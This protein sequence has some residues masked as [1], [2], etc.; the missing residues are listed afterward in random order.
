LEFGCGE[1]KSVSFSCD[2]RTLATVSGSTI[3]LWDV[4]SRSLITT[5][6]GDGADVYGADFHPYIG[7]LLV[8]GDKGD[9]VYRWNVR[10]RS[11]VAFSVAGSTGSLCWAW[12][13]EKTCVVVEC[14]Y[15]RMEMWDVNSLPV[16]RIQV[17]SS[18]QYHGGIHA[19][20]SNDDGTLVA[21]GSWNG[22]LTVY[23]THTGEILHSYKHS[24]HIHSIAFSPTAPILAFA[25]E[26]EVG[27]WFYATDRIVTFTGHVSH[28]TSVAFSPN[29]RFIASTSH[30]ATLRIWE[31]DA[32]DPAPDDFHHSAQIYSIHFLDD[33]QLIVSASNDK[34]VK[35]WDTLTGTL[36]ATLKGH[37]H[38]VYEVVMLPDNVHVVSRD[39][40]DTLMVSDWRQ[41]K[42]LFTD[43]ARA[44][45]GNHG[46]F[47]SLFA[48]TY[49]LPS[50]GFIS[51]HVKSH[52]S[53]ERIVCCWT[54]DPSVPGGTCVVLVARGVVN[55]SKSEILRI[56]HRG[57][58]ETSNPTLA[59]ECR[60]G[61]QFSALW[62][63]LD[64]VPTQL[65]FVQELEESP[66]N[67]ID[68]PLAG[69]EAPCRQSNDGSWIFDEHN[70][71]ILWVPPANRG[72]AA[73]WRGHHL[74]IG[75][76]SG[77]LTL[78][79]FSNVILNDDIEF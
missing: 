68:K 34:T 36:C 20:A 11:H 53:E 21:S 56:T 38:P 55:T 79:D 45:A 43:T 40:N 78:V 71:Q 75:S 1:V 70:R 27:L 23:S 72:F 39:A 6:V 64:V 47:K 59:L 4:V 65:Q 18:S 54:V 63:G 3:R 61:R 73:H 25:S 5:L 60:S 15:G 57:S 62:D 41:G 2:D 58:T 37:A 12:S 14:R 51:T 46:R 29:G 33:R 67:G 30:D 8:A 50:L 22:A 49:T 69:S 17:F 48:Y 35:F 74:V 28:V 52:D 24:Y 13:H 31:T 77:R 19:M 9:R 32:T 10:E 44:I 16:R 26:N 76:R 7:H 66:L 42:T